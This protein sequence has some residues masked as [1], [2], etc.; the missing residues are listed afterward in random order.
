MDTS[1]LV[2]GQTVWMKS[3]DHFKEATVTE[4]TEEYIAAKPVCFGQN[5]NPWMIHFQKDGKQFSVQAL[6][7]RTGSGRIDW[8]YLGNLGVYDWSCRGWERHDPRPEGGP[9]GPWELVDDGD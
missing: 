8:K 6:V 7:A 9:G 1:K 4:I 3:G 2:I 5:E